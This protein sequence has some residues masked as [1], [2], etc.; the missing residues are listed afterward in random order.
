[1]ESGTFNLKSFNQTG[2]GSVSLGADILADDKLSF[3]SLVT[4]TKSVTLTGKGGISFG[5]GITL[6]ASGVALILDAGAN[7]LS[8][9]SLGST[10]PILESINVTAGSLYLAGDLVTNSFLAISCPVTISASSTTIKGGNGLNVGAV[11]L[12]DNTQS[13]SLTLDAGVGDLTISKI[14]NLD[15]AL[16]SLNLLGNNLNLNGDIYTKG[17]ISFEK[18]V[19]IGATVMLQGASI[20]LGSNVTASGGVTIDN[21]GNLYIL[22]DAF[23]VHGAFKQ[24]GIGPVSLGASISADEILSFSSSLTLTKS[25]ALTGKGG[26]SFGGGITLTAPNVALILDAGENSLS[27]PSLGSTNPILESIN[28][29]AGSLNL[30]GDLFTNAAINIPSSITLSGTSSRISSSSGGVTING[31]VT[32]KDS[33][34]VTSLSLDAEGGDLTISKIGNSDAALAN[35]TLLGNNLNLNG[36]IYTKGDISFEKPI[37]IGTTV[38]LQGASI[39]LGD[40]SAS[41]AN[42]LTLTSSGAVS[43]ATLGTT[44]HNLGTVNINSASSLTLKGDLYSLS[45]V[46][47]SGVSIKLGSNVTA[48]GD[49][50]IKQTGSGPVFFEGVIHTQG[51]I[52]FGGALTVTADTILQGNKEITITGAITPGSGNPALT[53]DAGSN[54]PLTVNFAENSSNFFGLLTIKAST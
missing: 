10:N 50:T 29:T 35:L 9:P 16:A 5:G 31:I 47:L 11:S 23:T 25:T 32:L 49:V 2:T 36:D 45:T 40:L 44:D 53:L 12:K 13:T 28:V 34:Q 4:L 20:T 41:G 18:P 33:S 19:K 30:A 42:G 15:A 37:K 6:T 48:F 54:N 51:S 3:S 27:L 26:I 43:L 17:N 14:G 8:L 7:S 1:M 39:N 24:T 22:S 38:N 52:A 46:T 21:S